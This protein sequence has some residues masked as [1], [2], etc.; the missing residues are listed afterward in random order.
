MVVVAGER[1]AFLFTPEFGG[2][3]DK[4]T[5]VI[6]VELQN[7]EG[8]TAFLEIQRFGETFLL[9]YEGFLVFFEIPVNGRGT[10]GFE[11]F[12]DFE[13]NFEGRASGDVLHLLSHEGAR[14]FLHLNQKKV[15]SSLREA[16]TSSV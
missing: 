11:F 13:G 9:E 3:V 2:V 12:G 1:E 7:E 4:F 15:Q 8:D 16:M 10:Y 14:I 5:A 6:A